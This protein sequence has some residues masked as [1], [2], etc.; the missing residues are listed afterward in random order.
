M[1]AV[2]MKIEWKPSWGMKRLMG[3][4]RKTVAGCAGVGNI[5]KVH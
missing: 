2:D 3:R 4:E 5:P 1:Y